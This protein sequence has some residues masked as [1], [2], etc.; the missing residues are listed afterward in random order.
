PDTPDIPDI[1]DIGSGAGVSV[2]VDEPVLTGCAAYD[3]L[4]EAGQAEVLSGIGTILKSVAPFFLLCDRR[5]IGIATRVRDPHFGRPALY[6]YDSAPG[7]SGLSEAL[8]GTLSSVFAASSEQT[9]RCDCETGC[10]SCI[11]VDSTGAEIK[12]AAVDLLVHL[13]GSPA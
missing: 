7:G 1:P 9:A 11:G 6:I 5:D 2:D 3:E 13:A 8:A 4:D 10:P 12:R